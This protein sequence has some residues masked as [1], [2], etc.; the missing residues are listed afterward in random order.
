[1][2]VFQRTPSS[3]DERNNHETD[4]AWA[5]NQNP[6]GNKRMDNFN[7]LVSGGDQPEDL[8]QTVGPTS[9]VT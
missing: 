6:A 1:M 9:C 3:I 4:Q 2:Y 5:K 8:G 7:V